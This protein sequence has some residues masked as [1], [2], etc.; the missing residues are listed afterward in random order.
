MTVRNIDGWDP[1][2]ITVSHDFLVIFTICSDVW[3]ST[4]HNMH[5]HIFKRIIHTLS[6]LKYGTLNNNSECF[7]KYLKTSNQQ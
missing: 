6:Q 1:T 4:T 7:L 5:L 3:T 2:D